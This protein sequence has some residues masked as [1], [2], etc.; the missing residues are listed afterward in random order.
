MRTLAKLLTA[1]VA[2][3]LLPWA[4]VAADAAP[5]TEAP[6]TEARQ[7]EA[8]RAEIRTAPYVDITRESPTLPQIAEA[9]GQKH[10]TLA[11]VL[12]SSAGCDPRW[13]GELPLDDPRIVEQVDQLRAMGGDVIVASGGALGPYLENTCGSA[14]ELL[15]AYK[16][17]LDAVGA[18]HLDIDVEA[19]IPQ[20]M[21]N[22]ALAKLQAERQTQ[23]GYTLRVQSDDTG[24]D[25]YSVQVLQSAAAHGVAPLVNPMAMEFGSG[26]PWGDAV[27]A[28]AEST[29]GQMKQIWPDAGDAELKAQL[30]ITPM[31]GRNYNGK[32]FDQSHAR[33]LVDWAGAN[34]IGLLSFW[35]AGRDN[36]GCPG[37]P[38]SPE[39]SS[40]EQGDFEFTNIF[41]GFGG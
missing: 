20:D 30:G 35:S 12:G 29:L 5:R 9:T 18:N 22:E 27:I 4:V 17:T 36:G 33:Q 21:V 16:K 26:R 11:F 14:D 37:G 34:R 23:V 31:I 3:A 38:V 13:G 8:P 6:R 7:A 24:L 32:I 1:A 25:P 39:C 2:A 15:A 28:A 41:K 40:I 19:S 10:F